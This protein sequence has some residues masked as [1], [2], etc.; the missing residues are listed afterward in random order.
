MVG[1]VVG[2]LVA[3]A[4]VCVLAVSLLGGNASDQFTTVEPADGA[5]WTE[6]VALAVDECIAPDVGDITPVT[7]A[8]MAPVPCTSP[9]RSQV[10]AQAAAGVEDAPFPGDAAV[11]RQADMFCYGAGFEDF[12]GTEYDESTLWASAHVPTEQTWAEGH[13]HVTCF[14]HPPGNEPTTGTYRDSGL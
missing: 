2:A 11:D 9:H 8:E 3:I 13:R 6:S 7:P 5:P 14:V 10:F 12:V 4:F 1:S